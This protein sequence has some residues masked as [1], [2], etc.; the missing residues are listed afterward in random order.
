MKWLCQT[1]TQGNALQ[2]DNALCFSEVFSSLTGVPC[3]HKK[4]PQFG[5]IA[6][7]HV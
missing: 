4:G 5:L 1:K 2:A 6:I 7:M 3:R